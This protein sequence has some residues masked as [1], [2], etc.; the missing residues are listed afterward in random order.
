[1]KQ[2]LITIFFASLL[3]FSINAEGQ[4]LAGGIMDDSAYEQIPVLSIDN[5]QK[6]GEL[7]VSYS[8]RQ[9]TP[10][11]GNQGD[12]NSAVGWAFGYSGYTTA[13]AAERNWTNK[14]EI[15]EHA[16]SALYIY[17]NIKAGDCSSGAILT[18]A[19]DFLVDRGDTKYHMFDQMASNDCY[20]DPNEEHNSHA[21]QHT[22]K[23]YVA[24]FRYADDPRFKL[25]QVKNS[26]AAGKPVIIGMSILQ[27]FTALT[28]DDPFWRPEAGNS[29]PA[30][31]HAMTLIGYDDRRGAFEVMNSWGTDWGQEGYMWVRY[32]D[33]L[34]YTFYALQLVLDDQVVNTSAIPTSEPERFA[35]PTLNMYGSF[36]VRY[37][38]TDDFGTIMFDEAGEILFSGVEAYRSGNCFL[39][40]RKTWETGDLF[41]ILVHDVKPGT[42]VYLFSFDPNEKLE[43]HWPRNERHTHD[44]MVSSVGQSS[45]LV[46]YAS[47]NI[48]IPGEDRAMVIEQNEGDHILLL[49]AYRAIPNFQQ[50]LKVFKDAHGAPYDRL[51]RAFGDLFIHPAQIDYADEQIAFRASIG[52][53]GFVVPVCVKLEN[54]KQ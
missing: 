30:G 40:T 48:I 14:D 28:A 1:M 16:F 19:G 32:P 26:I 8:L 5:G 11:V 31:F 47:T 27:N 33:F 38:N 3:L 46:S 12:V 10:H 43:V 53:G 41:Q 18:D 21:R 29:E 17:N 49:Y 23:D 22:I 37:P 4:R 34:K 7:P 36:S 45:A 2:K 24:L 25:Y 15:T 42:Y 9:F 44:E 6:S 54:Y 50:R 52:E 13:M 35:N 20:K 51:G 39:L